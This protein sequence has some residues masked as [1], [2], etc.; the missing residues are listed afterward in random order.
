MIKRI[1]WESKEGYP[2]NIATIFPNGSVRGNHV[3][4]LGNA[5]PGDKVGSIELTEKEI[6]DI[7]S[8]PGEHIVISL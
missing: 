1:K 8:E 3:N 7:I 4:S 2:T 5:Y 6:K